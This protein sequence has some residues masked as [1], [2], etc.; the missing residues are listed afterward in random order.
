MIEM[1]Q[2]ISDAKRAIRDIRWP[3]NG[4]RYSF[5]TAHPDET[6]CVITRSGRGAGFLSNF[7]HVML[8]IKI[9]LQCGMTPVIDM[10]NYR[11]YCNE[12]EAI[13]GTYNAWEYFFE[14]PFGADLRDVYRSKNV[15]MA[16]PNYPAETFDVM[17]WEYVNDADKV[18]EFASLI[19]RHMS[20]NALTARFIDDAWRHIRRPGEKIL[21]VMSRGTDY[22]N[23]RPSRHPIQPEPETLLEMAS[24]MMRDTG[25]KWIFLKTEE[26]YAVRLFSDK[27]KD[28]LLITDRVF[29]DGL[30]K[31]EN[32]V[33]YKHDRDTPRY[34][35]SLEYLRDVV[36]ASR[37][38]FLLSGLNNGSVAAV[39]FNGGRYETKH[40]VD[41]GRYE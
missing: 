35:S 20:F 23:R 39:E 4:S 7:H 41:L 10:E 30:D 32:I 18:A 12:G 34:L 17:S 1:W 28:R 33:R 27:F 3:R 5:G 36:I 14:Q 26:E 31:G 15:F 37:C 13:N 25:A 22:R 2:I 9:A 38:D 6:F 16:T 11:T 8:H 24:E 19:S 40:I 21:A 29:F